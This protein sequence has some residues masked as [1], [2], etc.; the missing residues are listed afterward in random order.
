[1]YL[2]KSQIKENLYTAGGEWWY[3]DDGTEYIGF[4]YKLSNG[5]AYSGKNMNEMPSREIF[6]R[7]DAAEFILHEDFH[8]DSDETGINWSQYADNYDG[9][10]LGSK[11]NFSE[12][13]I[14]QPEDVDT[15][16]NLKGVD[17]TKVKHL[18]DYRQTLPT[19]EDY[20]IGYFSRYF[21][22][23]VNALIYMEIDKETYDELLSENSDWEWQSY[24]PFT[25]RWTITGTTDAV[26]VT[27]KN[28]IALKEKETKRKGLQNYLSNKLEY[29]LHTEGENLLAE[30][31][32]LI[33]G[34]GEDY[35]GYYHVHPLN[36]PME[37]PFHTNVP[38]KKLYYKRFYSSQGLKAIEKE[39]KQPYTIV[40][41]VD[42]NNVNYNELN[43]SSPMEGYS[44]NETPSSTPPPTN[45]G[46][47]T[48]GGY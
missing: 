30:P 48:G 41:G 2:P 12:G 42:D 22:V 24:I 34:T 45:G 26:F 35:T 47:S 36:G 6:Q 5:K 31:N 33:T 20:E 44:N 21:V 16:I 29:Y 43:Q 23:K 40:L 38:H 11:S 19:P 32:Q 39:N 27:N 9:I 17:A 8:V 14:Q 1:M 10:I 46:S 37:G 3:V 25:L 28:M 18:P 13:N 4:Y 15:Y 7:D